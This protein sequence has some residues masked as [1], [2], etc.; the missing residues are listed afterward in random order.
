MRLEFLGKDPGS[1]DDG[2]PALY[3]TDRGTYVVQGRQVTDP[4]ALADLR[5]VL[6]GETVVEVPREVLWFAAEM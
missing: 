6:D 5:N 2:C 4:N 1:G 3:A